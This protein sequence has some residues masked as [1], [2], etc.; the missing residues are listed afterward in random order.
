MADN[1]PTWYRLPERLPV[2]CPYCGQRIRMV[3]S[4]GASAYYEC[5]KDG[6]LVLPPDGRLR[7]APSN[8]S[9]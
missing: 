5:K 4:D 8:W 3:P 2:N 6:L 9:N 7:K 1:K